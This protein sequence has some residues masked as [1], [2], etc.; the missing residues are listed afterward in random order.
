MWESGG[1]TVEY[2]KQVKMLLLFPI[3]EKCQFLYFLLAWP[4]KSVDSHHLGQP[5]AMK[6]EREITWKASLYG[7]AA[8]SSQ[9]DPNPW[10]DFDAWLIPVG[11]TCCW[12]TPCRNHDCLSHCW[13]SVRE[14]SGIQM[15][16]LESRVALVVGRIVLCHMLTSA[17]G[18]DSVPVD[19]I[20]FYSS[21]VKK[22]LSLL[23]RV[24]MHSRLQ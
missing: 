19:L 24:L 14:T 23:S 1:Q 2:L 6:L 20:S 13:S 22:G 15:S 5:K 9:S 11:Q 21:S 4:L 8:V 17:A 18:V 3:R 7:P 16:T 12:H 10:N